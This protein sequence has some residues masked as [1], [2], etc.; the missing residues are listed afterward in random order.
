[1]GEGA[2]TLSVTVSDND[3]SKGGTHEVESA[4]RSIPLAK[5]RVDVLAY[6]EGGDLVAGL[7][8]RL[9]FEATLPNGDPADVT[10]AV[11]TVLGGRED[12]EVET[13]REQ[14]QMQQ[15]DEGGPGMLDSLRAF[16]RLANLAN[17]AGAGDVA[18]SRG[19]S[20]SSSRGVRAKA[21]EAS[22][23][24]PSR[25]LTVARTQ[26]E[27]KGV[28]PVFVVPSS[29]TGGLELRVLEPASAAR[30]IPLQAVRPFGVS[31]YAPESMY[32]GD[33]PVRVLLAST[34]CGHV[35]VG[36]YRKE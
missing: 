30:S 9:Y 5:H 25:C 32:S 33:G 2:D 26:H 27:G 11:C 4:S 34:H 12:M 14:R 6:P 29:G 3:D 35:T 13:W 23:A 22:V 7:P 15:Q 24:T 19:T 17:G 16:L 18:E 20:S 1:M 8:G 36:L 31:L 21:D 28:T 10:I